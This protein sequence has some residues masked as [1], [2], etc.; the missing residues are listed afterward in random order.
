S[1]VLHAV[2][3]AALVVRLRAP[4]QALQDSGQLAVRL[5]EAPFGSGRPGEPFRGFR[6]ALLRREQETG[7][8]KRP[9]VWAIVD[10]RP[11]ELH[12]RLPI[13]R[14]GAS[15]EDAPQ[16]GGVARIA[17][18]EGMS[19]VKRLQRVGSTGAR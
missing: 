18:I 17:R 2:V 5:C 6:E 1:Q 12:R 7:L 9:G 13:L 3:E 11:V 19:L 4:A 16:V 14:I 10:R 8:I 15:G